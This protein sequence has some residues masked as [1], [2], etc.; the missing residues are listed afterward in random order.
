V[1]YR[2]QL[3]KV[4]ALIE[5]PENWTQGVYARDAVGEPVRNEDD[6]EQVAL[7]DTAA[8]WCIWG[9]AYKCGLTRRDDPDFVGALGFVQINDPNDFNDS[10]THAE[11]LALLQSAIERAPVR[12]NVS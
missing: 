9:A 8:C 2:D 11:V 3:E 7:R 6:D 10:H 5:K 12:E 1:I 4:Y